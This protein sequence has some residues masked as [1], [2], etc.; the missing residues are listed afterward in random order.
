MGDDEQSREGGSGASKD[1][2]ANDASNPF[3]VHHSDHP[4]M[5][6]VPKPLTEI[7]TQRGAGQFAYPLAQKIS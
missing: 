1:G 3:F 6:L 7:I 5:V 2:G 4:G